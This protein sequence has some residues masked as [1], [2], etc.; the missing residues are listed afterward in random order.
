MELITILTMIAVVGSVGGG[1]VF[2]LT[3]ALRHPNTEDPNTE[4]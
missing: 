1:L 2:M 4:D 3:L